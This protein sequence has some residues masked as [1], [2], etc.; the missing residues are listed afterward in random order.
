ML[1]LKL[2]Q[3]GGKDGWLQTKQTLSYITSCRIN[4]VVARCKECIRRSKNYTRIYKSFLRRVFLCP[5]SLYQQHSVWRK[6]LFE[7]KFIKFRQSKMNS[8][9]VSYKKN[10][11]MNWFERWPNFRFSRAAR[12]SYITPSSPASDKERLFDKVERASHFQKDLKE[13]KPKEKMQ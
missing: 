10:E 3:R 6:F 2:V 12:E 5:F 4:V 7:F 1:S 8:G 13:R 9:L 11:D